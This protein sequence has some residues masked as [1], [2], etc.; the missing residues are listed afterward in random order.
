MKNCNFQLLT[1][2]SIFNLVSRFLPVSDAGDSQKPSAAV[3]SS[4]VAPSGAMDIFNRTKAAG[5]KVRDLKKAKAAKDQVTAAVND[6]LS[7][8]KEYKKLRNF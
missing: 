6:L 5:D 1:L 7:L 8:K 3:A 4:G 2:K